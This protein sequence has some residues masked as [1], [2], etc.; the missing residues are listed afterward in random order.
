MKQ[1]KYEEKCAAGI[2][3]TGQ[4]FELVDDMF[5]RDPSGRKQMIQDIVAEPCQWSALPVAQLLV[6]D[7]LLSGTVLISIE[8]RPSAL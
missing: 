7:H 4:R 3:N 1:D 8:Y 2:G 5:H 6:A